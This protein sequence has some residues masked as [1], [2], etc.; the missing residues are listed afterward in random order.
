[1][2]CNLKE[3]LK[4]LYNQ[5]FLPGNYIIDFPENYQDNETFIFNE[6]YNSSLNTCILESI[7]T[8]TL[9]D[10]SVEVIIHK[11]IKKVHRYEFENYFGF[12]GHCD[13][14]DSN[15]KIILCPKY[16]KI[17]LDELLSKIDIDILD[18]NKII[19]L[20]LIMFLLGFWNKRQAIN[21]LLKFLESEI[22]SDT[23]FEYLFQKL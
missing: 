11:P 4:K 12:E 6:K 8:I 20:C 10:I 14:F 19:E 13:G 18:D 2:S 15:K 5:Y 16:K 21:D 1:M 22:N 23:I 9:L 17:E 3:Q 7:Q